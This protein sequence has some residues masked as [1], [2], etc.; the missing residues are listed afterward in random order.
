MSGRFAAASAAAALAALVAAAGAAAHDE[1]L[2][3]G[4]GL[5]KARLGMTASQLRAAIG[6]PQSVVVQS[7]SFGRRVV[8]YQYSFGGYTITLRG[9]SGRER[10][11]AATTFLQKERT[12]HGVGAGSL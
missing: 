8:D 7:T 2:R 11:V 9:P 5:A 1:L 3:P 12:A 6:K 10:V 4:V